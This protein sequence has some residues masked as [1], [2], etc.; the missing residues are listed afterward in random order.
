MRKDGSRVPVQL[1]VTALKTIGGVVLGYIASSYDLTE[2]KRAE[3]EV[4]NSAHLDPADGPRHAHTLLRDRLQVSIELS[5]TL[6]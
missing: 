1:S 5:Q 3:A 6:R 2:Q 4:R